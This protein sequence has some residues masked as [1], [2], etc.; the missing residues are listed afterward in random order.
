MSLWQRQK[1]WWSEVVWK[2]KKG[3]SLEQL[4]YVIVTAHLVCRKEI[5]S[6]AV[7]V[8]VSSID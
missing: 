7:Q 1:N 3:H 5:G 4:K 8:S 6:F 2:P